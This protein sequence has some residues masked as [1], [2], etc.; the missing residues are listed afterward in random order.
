MKRHWVIRL[1]GCHVMRQYNNRKF[2]NF[3][4]IMSTHSVEKRKKN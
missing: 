1:N 3:R 4:R 2:V